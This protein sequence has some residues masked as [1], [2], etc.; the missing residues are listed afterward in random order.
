MSTKDAKA[1]LTAFIDEVDEQNARA[2][3]NMKG[4]SSFVSMDDW[5]A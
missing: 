4:V 5:D 2:G 1:H 3:E